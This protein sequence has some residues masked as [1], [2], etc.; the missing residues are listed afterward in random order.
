MKA[1][2]AAVLTM[3]LLS[4]AAPAATARETGG[5]AGKARDMAVSLFN[6]GK[7]EEA[8]PL[9]K[10]ILSENPDD[11]VA[12]RYL[13]IYNQQVVE[14]YCRQAAQSYFAGDYPSAV[15]QWEKILRIN[16]NDMRVR[17]LLDRTI[18]VSNQEALDSL[19]SNVTTLMKDSRYALAAGELEK[20]LQIRPLEQRAHELLSI[21]RRTLTDSAVKELYEKANQYFE[22][23]EYDLAIEQWRK[24]LEVDPGQDLASRQIATVH[25]RKL[26]KMYTTAE[27]L[28]LEGDLAASRDL[29]SNILSENPTDLS[30]KKTIDRLNGTINI[31][32]RLTEEGKVWDVLRKGVAH[33]VSEDGNPR[34]AVAAAWYAVQLEPEN[35]T[36]LALM[37]H[38][39]REN[40]AV[41]R[42]MAPP[43]DEMNVV[44]QY[45]FTA[46]N[47]IYEGRYDLAVQECGI[48]LELEP[49]NILAMK[50]LGSAYY[51]LG[52]AGKA[53]KAWQKALRLSPND[54]E[55]KGFIKQLR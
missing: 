45:L 50:R 2:L 39:E 6:Q 42:T 23:K 40:F 55:L 11:K 28:Y 49:E 7:Y 37:D 31:V 33:H 43:V 29:Y 41:V 32:P 25:R 51:A 47:N 13:L 54:S 4:W 5:K 27:R 44:D 3:L 21:V 30:I 38:M 22:Q 35:A 12:Q 20:I 26:D 16:P 24:I 46:L 14:P 48:V 53:K 34:V 17:K 19:Y 8:L 10:E 52:R 15:T 9:L 1:A 18:T 36:I